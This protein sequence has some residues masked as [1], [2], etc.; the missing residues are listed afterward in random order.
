MQCKHH[1]KRKA[2][3]FCTS[4]GIPLC[5]DCSQGVKLEELLCFYCAMLYSVSK[6]ADASIGDNIKTSPFR[7]FL[8]VFFV[9]IFVMWGVHL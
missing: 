1:P 8:I 7:C 2:E 6:N 3:H 9:A 5:K 4:C